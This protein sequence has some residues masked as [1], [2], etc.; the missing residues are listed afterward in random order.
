[1]FFHKCN[2]HDI[3]NFETDWTPLAVSSSKLNQRSLRWLHMSVTPMTPYHSRLSCFLFATCVD[4]Q[5]SL[6]M[7]P[8]ILEWFVVFNGTWDSCC[9]SS[10]LMD[11]YCCSSD[12]M[13]GYCC[14]SDLVDGYYCSSDLVDGYYCSSDLVDG[15]YCSSDLV[16][17]YYCSS[18]LMDSYCCSSDLV[19][20]FCCSSDLMDIFCCSSDLMDYFFAVHLT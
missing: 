19:D 14:L 12:L 9:C 18:D 15:Y 10:D 3:K 2:K 13:D 17:G 20:V 11:S 16:D 8:N 7:N 1:M 6:G 4:Y 5:V